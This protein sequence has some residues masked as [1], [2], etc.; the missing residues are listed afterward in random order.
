VHPD[1]EDVCRI[2]SLSES[3]PSRS[4]QTLEHHDKRWRRFLNYDLA[5]P[6]KICHPHDQ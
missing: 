5:E 4:L 6:D 3:I 1:K 2:A